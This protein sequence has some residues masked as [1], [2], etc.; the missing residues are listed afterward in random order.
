MIANSLHKLL[1]CALAITAIFP[2]FSVHAQGLDQSITNLWD[3]VIRFCNDDAQGEVGKMKSLFKE[4]DNDTDQDICIYINNE[5]PTDVD[6]QLNFV[7]GTVSADDSQNKACQPEGTKTQ[8]GQFVDFVDERL[9]VK[10]GTTMETHANINFP[11]GYS[12]MSYGCVTMRFLNDEAEA[13]KKEDQMFNIVSRRWYFI[14]MLVWG[15]V[16]LDFEVLDQTKD[17]FANIGNSQKLGIYTD[18]KWVTKA[19]VTVENPGNIAQEVT[20]VP[21][22]KAMFKDSVTGRNVLRQSIVNNQIVNE[23]LL[24]WKDS[25]DAFEVKKKVLPNQSVTFEFE[26]NDVIPFW[27]W[28]FQLDAIIKNKP[29][30][31]YVIEGIDPELMEEKTQSF[32]A[33]FMIIPWIPI[34]ILIALILIF[35]ILVTKK[36]T[37][38]SNSKKK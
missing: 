29:V 7:D 28:T 32:S 3:V 25:S 11:D 16:N 12:G 6:V 26:L 31:D 23:Y 5:G 19:K 38:K 1:I 18:D 37:V 13:D 17:G 33:S 10:A 20:V 30:F 9:T 14:D 4:V 8:F 34:G 22:L 35:I 15:D 36:K 21:T 24:D 27:K 2:I